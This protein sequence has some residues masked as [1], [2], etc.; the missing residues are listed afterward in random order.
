MNNWIKSNI[1]SNNYSFEIVKNKLKQIIICGFNLFMSYLYLKT[2]KMVTISHFQPK[3][4]IFW[5]FSTR[6]NHFKVDKKI[7]FIFE[8][9]LMID[10]V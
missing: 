9:N 2:V 10:S 5:L 6:F 3:C 1:K 7:H 4:L 8:T